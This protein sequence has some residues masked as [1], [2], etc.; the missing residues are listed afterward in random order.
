M[1]NSRLTDP[2]VLELRFPVVLESYSIRRGSGGTGHWRGGDGGTR[3]IRFLEPMT[4]AILSNGRICPAQGVAG[5][6]DGEP[7]QTWIERRDGSLVYLGACD[8]TEVQAGDA[9]VIETPGGGGFG[10]PVD[11]VNP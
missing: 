3:K 10:L 1:T 4:V 11:P 2:E 7:G 5:G 9:V 8:R 6:G